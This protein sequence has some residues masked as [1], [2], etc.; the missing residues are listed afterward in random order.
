MDRNSILQIVIPMLVPVLLVIGAFFTQQADL[1]H[2]EDRL[3]ADEAR[4]ESRIS[5]LEVR[6]RS[7]EL[8]TND[9]LARIETLLEVI[10]AYMVA[11]GER[12]N[13]SANMTTR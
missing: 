6:V 4:Y 3:A 10:E 2:L 8:Q 7:S 9:R 12:L 13:V 5:A 11:I 1:R